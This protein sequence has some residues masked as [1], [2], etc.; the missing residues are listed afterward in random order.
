[1]TTTRFWIRMKVLKLKLALPMLA[2]WMLLDLTGQLELLSSSG[3]A[4]VSI[5]NLNP[6]FGFLDVGENDDSDNFSVQV[7]GGALECS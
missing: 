1:M 2:D 6:S 4:D 5:E 3:S 7:T